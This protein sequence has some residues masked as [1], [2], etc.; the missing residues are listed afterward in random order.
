MEKVNVLVT[1]IGGF[2]HGSSIVKALL[3]SKL[4]LNIIG[5]DASPKMI[6]TSYLEKKEIV[7][8][9]TD[10]RYIECIENIIKKNSIQCIFTGSEQE[11]VFWNKKRNF[12]EKNFNVKL[13]LNAKEVISLCKNKFK[14]AKK[15]Y[16]LGFSVP[17]TTLINSL[18]DCEK[19]NE[20][21]V[22]IKPNLESGASANIYF[23]MN[24][25]ELK[26]ISGY[27]L[28]NNI[29]IITQKYINY[30][31]N[32]YTAGVTSDDKGQICSSIVLHKFLE[33]PTKGLRI[34]SLQISSGVTQGQ[35]IKRNFINETCE[36]IARKIG[37]RGPLNIQL[38]VIDNTVYPFEI[39]P[40]FSGTTSA[41][42]YNGYNEPEFFIR[43]YIL[44]DKNALESLITNKR[45]FIVKGLDEKYF[46]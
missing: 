9:T 35:F 36:A 15:L 30:S 1:S 46:K 21:P 5:V 45:V 8:F 34:N 22:I 40:R 29:E 39:N 12:I 6:L 37:S 13:F 32:E 44:S 3:N 18:K 11:L 23:A 2:S 14:C 20:Y 4:K 28:R 7:P 16:D 10:D 25:K 24:K 33:G 38:R 42:A 26:F 27:L 17:D 31:N 41:R 19:I 43:K